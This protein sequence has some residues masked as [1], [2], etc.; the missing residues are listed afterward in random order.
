MGRQFINEKCLAIRVTRGVATS[1]ASQHP[2]DHQAR[3]ARDALG[4]IAKDLQVGE[5]RR[6]DVT[7]Q[8]STG[9]GDPTGGDY[10]TGFI[11][12]ERLVQNGWVIDISWF[13]L[14]GQHW[15]CLI[16]VG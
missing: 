13:T 15:C 14:L 3:A 4:A 11:Q 7:L 2:D 9:M 8:K 6:H 1:S 5:A 16:T 10:S 12:L